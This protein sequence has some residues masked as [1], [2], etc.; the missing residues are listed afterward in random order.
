MDM[1]A[2]V[3]CLISVFRK[4]A[5]QTNLPIGLQLV[6]D[7]EIGG[8]D[9]TKFQVEQGVR[10]KLV[11]AGESTGFDIANQAKGVLWLKISCKGQSAH[12]AY[13]WKGEN[14]I[15][16]MKGFLDTLEQK[17]PM[18]K[19]A[20]WG[21]TLNLSWIE[22]TNKNLNKVPDECSVYLDI[23]F[24]P[25][26]EKK[27]LSEI[28]EIAPKGFLVE[29]L[30]KEPALQTPKEDPMLQLLL[31]ACQKETGTEPKLYGA[32]GS[33]DARHYSEVGCKGVEFGPIGGGIGSDEEWVDIPSL[34]AYHN[35][36]SGFLLSLNQSTQKKS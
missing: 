11:I 26:S 4:A 34:A 2:S 8:F 29:V 21:N 14:A 10:A 20:H 13:T 25:E 1:K 27:I 6:T 3:A 28:K 19:K 23:R 33:S 15:W 12:G 35:I 32:H 30:A 24:V 31:K 9:G 36:L 5:S 16:K 18:P 17:Y 7:E 22:T